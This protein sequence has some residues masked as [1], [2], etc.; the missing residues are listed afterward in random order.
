VAENVSFPLQV[1]KV[2][3][4]RRRERVAETLTLLRIDSLANQRPD[5]L[6]PIQRRRA[7]LARALV[8]EPEFL[9][10]DEPF[11]GLEARTRDELRDEI[12]R[13]HGETEITT[14]VLTRDAREALA[15]AERVAVLDLGRVL[16]SGAP[17]E[18][19]NRPADA[20]V[21][22]LLGPANLF[23][24]QVEG[25]DARGEVVVRTPFGR[26]V[27]QAAAPLADGAPVT[28]AIRP[29]A[30]ALGPVA[31]GSNR[32]NATIERL[33]FLGE[34]RL[35]HLRGPGDWPVLALALQGPSQ[36]LREGQSV[37]LSVA[38]E[39]VVVLPGKYAVVK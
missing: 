7:A 35:V 2:A 20:F 16:Q 4:I 25:T 10:L 26:L 11:G 32:F 21:A 23:Q 34:T 13:L 18:V 28:V 38:P 8:V 6:S 9:V 15:V 19:Y 3:R 24:G 12:L 1:Q 27:G 36:A 33:T 14:L 29:E 37:T 39:F 30:L 17:A 22:R 31:T 5:Q